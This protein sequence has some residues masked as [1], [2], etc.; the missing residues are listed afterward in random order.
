M[1]EVEDG[2]SN[3]GGGDRG[4]GGGS[5]GGGEGNLYL[6]SFLTIRRSIQLRAHIT[7]RCLENQICSHKQPASSHLIIS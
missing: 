3:R 7:E 6:I 5:G 2:E 1:R 4:M